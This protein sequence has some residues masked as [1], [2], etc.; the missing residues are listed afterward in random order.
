MTYLM[1]VHHTK[2]PFVTSDCLAK[3]LLI[4]GPRDLTWAAEGCHATSYYG[5][6]DSAVIPASFMNLH[7]MGVVPRRLLSSG[8]ACRRSPYASNAWMS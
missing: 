3:P 1:K 4:F 2:D 5:I 7:T 8:W 6:C